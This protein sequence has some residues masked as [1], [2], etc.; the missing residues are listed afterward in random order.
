MDFVNLNIRHI[1]LDS[2]VKKLI[3]SLLCDDAETLPEKRDLWE[4]I[5]DMSMDD[6]ML[7]KRPRYPFRACF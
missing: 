4:I 2:A 1:N 6:F 5:E 7:L 3:K